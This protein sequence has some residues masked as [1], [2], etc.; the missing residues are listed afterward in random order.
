MRNKALAQIYGYIR[1]SDATQKINRQ[2][3]FMEKLGIDRKNIS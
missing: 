3:D 1:I 2:L